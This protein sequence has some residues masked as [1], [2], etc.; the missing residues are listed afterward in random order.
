[1]ELKEILEKEVKKESDDFLHTEAF[2]WCKGAEEVEDQE[3]QEMSDKALAIA[4]ILVFI[5]IIVIATYLNERFGIVF[6]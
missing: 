3:K 1:M 4:S 5:V 2:Q 6:E